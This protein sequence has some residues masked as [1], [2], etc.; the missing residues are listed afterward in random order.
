MERGYLLP[1]GHK[2][3]GD[4]L[5]PPQGLSGPSPFWIEKVR[6]NGQI[7]AREVRVI[8]MGGQQLG[9]MK[10]VKAL[11]LARSMGADLVEIASHARPPVCRIID[12]G[13]FLREAMDRRKGKGDKSDN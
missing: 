8:G 5:K 1:F 11:R 4:L 12:Y 10:L 6:V 9:I 7:R 2:N 3:L 13:K